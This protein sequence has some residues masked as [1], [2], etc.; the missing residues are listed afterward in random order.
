MLTLEISYRAIAWAFVAVFVLLAALML[1]WPK[2]MIAA[3]EMSKKWVPTDDLEKKLNRTH[4][5]DARLMNWRK[6]LGAL[7]LLLAI[8]FAVMAVR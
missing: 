2:V 8:A 1:F 4:D 3:N 7:L 6:L 5:I